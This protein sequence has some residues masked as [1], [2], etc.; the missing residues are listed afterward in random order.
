[1]DDTTLT[2]DCNQKIVLDRGAG[3]GWARRHP[4]ESREGG[5]MV[6]TVTMCW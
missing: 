1:M 2:F 5:G 3:V 6:N 4:T